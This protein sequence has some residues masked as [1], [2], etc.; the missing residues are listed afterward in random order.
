MVCPEWYT[1][2]VI[3]LDD[4]I[5]GNGKIMDFQAFTVKFSINCNILLYYKIIKAIMKDCLIEIEQFVHQN[6]N[7][8]GSVIYSY[9]IECP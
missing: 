2:G 7:H 4:M 6:H 1:A 8:V 5:D 3:R 9:K